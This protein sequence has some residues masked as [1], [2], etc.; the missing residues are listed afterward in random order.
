MVQASPFI[1]DT[2]QSGYVILFERQPTEFYRPNRPSALA[3]AEFV[4]QAISELMEDGRVKEVKVQ[5]M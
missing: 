1:L 2:V 3:N 5:G 4:N